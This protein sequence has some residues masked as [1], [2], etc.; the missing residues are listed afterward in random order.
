MAKVQIIFALLAVLFLASFE[1]VSGQYYGY[2]YG[3]YGYPSAYGYGYGDYGYGGYSGYY[4]GSY[5]GYYGKRS[6]GVEPA[7][8]QQQ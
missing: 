7:N 6:V 1:I 3:A 4:P 2:G 5:Y 8:N